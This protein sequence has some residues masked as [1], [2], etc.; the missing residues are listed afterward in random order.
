M[1][2]GS[3]DL[4]TKMTMI[5]RTWDRVTTLVTPTGDPYW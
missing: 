3:I 1:Y 4:T 2:P 5:C